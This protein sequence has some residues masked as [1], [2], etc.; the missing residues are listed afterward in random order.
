[1][2][3]YRISTDIGKDKNIVVELK[4]DFDNIEILSLSFTQQDIYRSL[5]A[6]YGVVC[7]RISANNGLGIP[8]TRISIFVPLTDE[9]ENDTVI[10]TLYPYKSVEDKDSNYSF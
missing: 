7:G 10:S 9:D 4:Q 1:M 3:N 5:C 8:N 6:D 2:Q